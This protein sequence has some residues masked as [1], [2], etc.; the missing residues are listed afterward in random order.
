VRAIAV[1]P[2]R[3]GSSRIPRKN[4]RIL[5]DRPVLGHTIKILEETGLF[6]DVFVSTDDLQIKSIAEEYGAIVPF[7]RPSILAQN[8]ASTLSVVSHALGELG[9]DD[10]VFVLCI[11]PVNPLVLPEVIKICHKILLERAHANY[12][13]TIVRYGFPI[14]RAL[15]RKSEFVYM[16]DPKNMFVNSQDLTASFHETGQFWWG[17]S[18]TWKAQIGMQVGLLGVEVPEIL[19]QDVDNEVD[20]EIMEL[21]YNWLKTNLDLKQLISRIRSLDSNTIYFS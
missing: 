17:K 8:D 14:Q 21:K 15:T 1:I 6:E 3:G 19:Q 18:S 20:W 7:I 2:A 11:Y 9:I 12:V 16:I 4:I 10:D 5:D 13:T